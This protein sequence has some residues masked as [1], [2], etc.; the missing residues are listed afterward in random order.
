M[1]STVQLTNDHQQ[2]QQQIYMMYQDNPSI[3]LD[4]TQIDYDG[5]VS[6][7]AQAAPITVQWLIDNF[8]PAEGCSL[9]RSTLYNYYLHHCTEQKLEP[10]NPAS[11]GKLIRSVFLGLRT[12][13]LGTRGNSKY[14]YYGIRVKISSPLNQ[15]AEDHALAIRNHPLSLSPTGS[16]QPHQQ[17]QSPVLSSALN[18]NNSHQN[19]P[20]PN[21]RLKTSNQ[22]N[23]NAYND[24][25]N[26]LA[27]ADYKP[28]IATVISNN[29]IGNNENQS[30]QLHQQ[31]QQ[32]QLQQHHHQAQA[33]P[34]QQLQHQAGPL[35]TVVLSSNGNVT[36]SVPPT[37]TIAKTLNNKNLNNQQQVQAQMQQQHNNDLGHINHNNVNGSELN[38]KTKTSNQNIL[39]GPGEQTNASTAT[40]TSNTVN[41]NFS[42]TASSNVNHVNSSSS[43]SNNN[44][45]NTGET[46]GE[47]LIKVFLGETNQMPNFGTVNLESI[48][49]PHNCT[50]DDVK[51]FEEIYKQHCDVIFI[52]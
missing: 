14:H 41:N 11:F 34:Q 4:S 12:R 1:T 23:Y 20:T 27:Q 38:A 8:E 17:P 49:L 26:V 5:H 33:L 31:Q 47:E 6:H 40:L 42:K 35:M 19:G 18:N 3:D 30:Q 44:N 39:S 48:Q 2:Q 9:R 25:S 52:Y 51:I 32:Q 15:L 16:P 7:T 43:S 13:R 22:T 50:L 45:N 37:T 10:V 28:V 36:K 29:N 24:Q 21:K 46:S